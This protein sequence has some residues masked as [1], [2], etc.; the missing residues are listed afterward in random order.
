MFDKKYFEKIKKTLG[1]PSEARLNQG[2]VAVIE[3]LEEIPCNPC[4]TVCPKKSITVGEPITNLPKINDI[5]TGCGKCVVVCPGLA[6]FIVDRTYSETEA[7][8]TVP[9]ELFPLPNKGDKIIGL[10]R[11]GGPVCEGTVLKVN[12]NKNFNRTNLVTIAVPKKCSYE[13]RF[14]KSKGD[15]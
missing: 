2:P 4:E 12:S 5:C 9:Y 1:Y 7:A 10:N 13:V 3:C 6:I 8:I 11:Q 15:K 14:F